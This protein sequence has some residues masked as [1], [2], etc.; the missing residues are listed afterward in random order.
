MVH[1]F[2]I[3]NDNLELDIEQILQYPA[4]S[5]I[6]KRDDSKDKSF[7]YKEFKFI[8]F[9]SDR[10]GYI[11]KA[12]LNKVEAYKF[13]KENSG[14]SEL[15]QPDKEVLEAIEFIKKNLNI[16]AVEDLIASTIKGLK[17]S[18]KVIKVLTEGLED[19]LS[20]EVDTKDLITCEETLK[21]L[22]EI[23]ND[24]P[25]RIEA[26][27]ELNDKWDKMEKGVTSIRG[28][29]SYRESYDG[30]NDR[31]VNASDEIETLQ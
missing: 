30:T 19:I 14:L 26:L 7:A 6:Y 18:S 31:A 29:L 27:G 2:K 4:L 13:A 12:G 22:I 8:H 15:Y 11:T 28:G 10:K 21:K 16:T 3:E 24:I 25:D 20:K 5:V 9:L 1:A 17:L 23:S